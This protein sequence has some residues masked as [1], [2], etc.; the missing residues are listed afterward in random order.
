MEHPDGHA[1]LPQV[2]VIAA[3]PILYLAGSAIYR[4]VVYGRIPVSHLVGIVAALA[5]APVGLNANLLTMGWLTTLLLAAVAIWESRTR[6]AT[7]VR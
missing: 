4:R 6:R 2:L 7:L 5:L 1:T 3:G